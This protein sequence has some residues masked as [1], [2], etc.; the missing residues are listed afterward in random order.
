MMV[1]F[2]G[3]LPVQDMEPMNECPVIYVILE[4]QQALKGEQP[5]VHV[6]P[7]AGFPG[8]AVLGYKAG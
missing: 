5:G 1:A 3:L 6:M 4:G 2:M 8:T 7:V